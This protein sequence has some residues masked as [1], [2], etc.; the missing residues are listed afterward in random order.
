MSVLQTNRSGGPNPDSD[1]VRPRTIAPGRQPHFVNRLLDTMEALVVVLNTNGGIVRFNEKCEEVTGYSAAEVQGEDLV[2]LLIPSDEQEQVRHVFEELSRG[3]APYHFENHWQT[4][5]GK[6]RRIRWANTVLRGEGN[7]VRV[8]GTGIDVT[9]QRELERKVVT[10]TN[11][12]RRRIAEELHDLLTPQLSGTA[13]MV[14]VLAQKLQDAHPEVATELQTAAERVRKA[15]KQTRALSHSLMPPAI[16]DGDLASGLHDLAKR[17]EELRD[18]ACSVETVGPVPALSEETV[19]HL[20]HIASEVVANAAQ[21]A[22]PE[23]I[24]LSLRTRDEHVLLTVRDD[25]TGMPE[26]TDPSAGAGL[27]IMDARADVI[28]ADLEI[29]PIEEGG[30]RVACKLPLEARPHVRSSN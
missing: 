22:D 25:G 5:E 20:Y 11:E 6:R 13:L 24:T 1:M 12:E 4:K 19:T 17:Q 9:K 3:H 30:T 14:E 29:A 2:D 10:A 18:V 27:H 16:K 26:Q 7:V 23:E 15:G 21:H 8:V 28:G